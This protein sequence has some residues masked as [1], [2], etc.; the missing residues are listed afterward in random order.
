MANS[1]RQRGWDEA[2]STPV[3]GAA[4]RRTPQAALRFAQGRLARPVAPAPGPADMGG[5]RMVSIE[6]SEHGAVVCTNA[7]NGLSLYDEHDLHVIS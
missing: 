5:N 2:D 1:C 6:K 4:P 7:Q 3:R